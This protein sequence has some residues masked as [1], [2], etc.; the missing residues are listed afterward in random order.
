MVIFGKRDWHLSSIWSG[1][2]PDH[3]D[4]QSYSAPQGAGVVNINDIVNIIN[5]GL[6]YVNKISHII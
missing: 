2:R 5:I 3:G 4:S 1:L 6:S